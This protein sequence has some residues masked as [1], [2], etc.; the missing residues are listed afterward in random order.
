MND[1]FD[2]IESV[3]VLYEIST[4]IRSDSKLEGK[5]IQALGIVRDAVGCHSASLFIHKGK[6][7]KLEEVA[8]IGKRVDLI[9]AID[10]DM[11]KGFSAWVAKHR[12]TVLIPNLS[13]KKHDGFRSFISIPL[14]SSD[15]LIGVMNL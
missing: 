1:N 5:F 8:T 11:G 2:N 6:S 7:G 3:R 4:L 13:K 12:K 15:E 9:E 14:I 10:F